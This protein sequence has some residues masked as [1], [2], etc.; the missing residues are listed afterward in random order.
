[1]LPFLLI[2]PNDEIFGFDLKHEKIF[3]R[4]K[5]SDENEIIGSAEL[6]NGMETNEFYRTYK[7]RN[8]DRNEYLKYIVDFKEKDEKISINNNLMEGQMIFVSWLIL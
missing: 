6:K 5:D 1:M 2:K 3:I 8:C 7:V 4:K